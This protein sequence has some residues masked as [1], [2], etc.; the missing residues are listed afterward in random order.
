[1]R[2]DK[3]PVKGLSSKEYEEALKISW[4]P[5]IKYNW[6]NGKAIG[7][8]LHELKNGRIIARVC[9]KC[10]RIMIPPRMF[11]ELCFRPTD[12]WQYVKDTGKVN[13]YAVCRIYWN[14]QRIPEGEPPII[15]A[16]IE[17]DGASEGMGI[18]HLLGNV[19]PQDIKI[20]MRVK[21]VWRPENERIGSITDILYFEPIKE[22][23]ETK[24]R[25]VTKRR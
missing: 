5:I 12:R 7:R 10:D 11:C 2:I 16:V 19:E 1:M 8:Y 13:T 21:A 23:S 3:V 14:A 6:D 25:P 20:G 24:M 22:V 15:P 17:I 18:L 9:D 4:D